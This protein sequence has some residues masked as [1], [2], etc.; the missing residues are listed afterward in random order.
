VLQIVAELGELGVGNHAGGILC[1]GDNTTEVVN[2]VIYTGGLRT[3]KASSEYKDEE[4]NLPI[5]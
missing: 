4:S 3:T 1:R 5:R 2:T